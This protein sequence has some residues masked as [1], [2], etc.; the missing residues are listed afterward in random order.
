MKYVKRRSFAADSASGRSRATPCLRLRRSHE[1]QPRRSHRSRCHTARHCPSWWR[2]TRRRLA[3]QARIASAAL[4]ARTSSEGS[5]AA[6]AARSQ[7]R[8][9]HSQ[10]RSSRLSAPRT[11]RP[12]SRTVVHSG[13]WI[14]RVPSLLSPSV[15]VTAPHRTAP[16]RANG[17]IYCLPAARAGSAEPHKP[18]A[19]R[20]TTP[21]M[22]SGPALRI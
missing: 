4:V 12:V 3:E 20:A 2:T 9:T 14:D 11:N 8:D 16:P 18:A 5:G 21:R 17:G 7:A 22:R 13:R 10:S 1:G 6:A 15:G 19:G